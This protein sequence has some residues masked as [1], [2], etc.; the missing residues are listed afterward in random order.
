MK[1]KLNALE[2]LDKGKLLKKIADELGVGKTTVKNCIGGTKKIQKHY[3]FYFS[4]VLKN[5]LYLKRQ[6]GNHNVLSVQ[7]MKESQQNSTQENL[8]LRKSPGPHQKICEY[9]YLYLF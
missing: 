8:T 4:S 6:T 9:M 7:F 3:A 1:N 2:K 5:S